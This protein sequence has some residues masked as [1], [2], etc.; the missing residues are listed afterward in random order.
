MVVAGAA[1]LIISG[2]LLGAA[3]LVGGYGVSEGIN[4]LGDTYLGPG[5]GNIINGSL[6]FLA[7]GLGSVASRRATLRQQ[8]KGARGPMSGRP[9]N[10]DEAGGPIRSLSTDNIKIKHNGIDVV[11]RHVSRFGSDTFNEAQIARLRSIADGKIEAT[12][13]DKSFYSH[14]LREYVRYRSLG[15]R[16][17]QPVDPDA[18][19]ELWNNTHTATLE[20]NGLKEGPGVLY[21]PGNDP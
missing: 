6:G 19:H 20:D 11:E 8:I 10:P 16:D 7:L 17:G 14:E 13:A 3:Y 1:T 15:W 18:A 4:Y 2:P 21:H 9:Y 5:W 12:Q